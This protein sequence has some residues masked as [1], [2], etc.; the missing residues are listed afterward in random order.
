MGKRK[1][2][3]DRKENVPADNFSMV[4]KFV[5]ADKF[6]LQTGVQNTGLEFKT[7]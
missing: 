5:T 7:N 3:H 6:G 2:I 4:E 1:Q